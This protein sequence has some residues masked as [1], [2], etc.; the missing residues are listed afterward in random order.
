MFDQRNCHH[1]DIEA[2]GSFFFFFFKYIFSGFLPLLYRTVEIDRKQEAERG[3]MT[4]R[5]RLLGLG[6]ELGSPAKRTIASTHEVGAL[7]AELCS[8]P[9]VWF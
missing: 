9:E 2:G 6:F 7:P 8:T 3:G 4:R 1:S 5:I